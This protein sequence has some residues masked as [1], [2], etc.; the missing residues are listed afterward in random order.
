MDRRAVVEQ[1]SEHHAT[2][3]DGRV[4]PSIETTLDGFE[5]VL[6]HGAC[7]TLRFPAS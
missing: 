7:C 1:R 5:L 4:E 3:H 6:A 2:F